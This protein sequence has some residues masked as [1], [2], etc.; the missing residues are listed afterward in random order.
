M[1]DN[2]ARDIS[3]ASVGPKFNGIV[4]QNSATSAKPFSYIVNNLNVNFRGNGGNDFSGYGSAL[5]TD[6]YA[7]LTINKSRFILDGVV[8]NAATIKGH[9]TLTINDS[10][11]ETSSPPLPAVTEGMM[12]VPWMLGLTGTCRSTNII[13]YGSLN[14]NRSYIKA[15]GWGALSTDATKT[16]RTNVKNSTIELTGSGYGAYSIGD[17]VTTFDRCNIKVKDMAL[18]MANEVACGT[19]TN[20]S[21]VK[22]DRFGVMMHSDNVGTLTIDKGSAFDCGQTV[23]QAKSAYPEIVVDGAKLA[24]GTGVILQAMVNDDPIAGAMPGAPLPRDINAGFS[25]TTLAGDIVNSNTTKANVNVFLKNATLTGAITTAT[26]VSEASLRGVD[27]TKYPGFS[28]EGYAVAHLIGWVHNTYAPTN[29]PY[30]VTATVDADSTWIVD[31]TSY[32]TGLT[33]AK[34]ATITAPAGYKVAMTVDGA[35]QAMRPGSYAGAI[36]LKVTPL[37]VFGGTALGPR[38]LPA[39]D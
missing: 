26:V 2:G 23:I 14:I 9:S 19:F 36:I 32:L 35:W 37:K 1:T 12:G 21:V 10:Y 17:S 20:G 3:I 11:I 33:I 16:V 13:D 7:A 34:G 24:S 31:K 8:R 4:V 38:M 6:G 5:M 15:A 39:T 29:D 25:N 27:F 28:A 18:I 22:S 30:G